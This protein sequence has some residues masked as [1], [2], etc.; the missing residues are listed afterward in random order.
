M[1]GAVLTFVDTVCF[2]KANGFEKKSSVAFAL[3]YDAL[4]LSIFWFNLFNLGI[5]P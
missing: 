5:V 4:F 2:R 1:I 3:N